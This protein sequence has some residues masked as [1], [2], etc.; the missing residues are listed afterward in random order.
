MC[1]QGRPEETDYGTRILAGEVADA[2]LQKEG[3]Q[4][5]YTVVIWREATSPNRRNWTQPRQPRTGE[6][7]YASAARSRNTCRR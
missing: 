5:G 4:R 7:S 1:A 3:K 2:Y 6:N